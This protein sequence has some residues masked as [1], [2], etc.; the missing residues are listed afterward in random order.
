M[1]KLVENTMPVMVDVLSCCGVPTATANHIYIKSRKKLE[2]IGRDVILSEVEGGNFKN[3]GQDELVSVIERYM[4]C[5]IEGVA[6]RNLRLM[7]K[8]IRGMG[9]KNELTAQS[10]TKYS[11]ALASLTEEEIRHLG[12]LCKSEV[13]SYEKNMK[14]TPPEMNDSERIYQSL[15]RTGLVCFESEVDALLKQSNLIVGADEPDFSGS[16]AIRTRVT[17]VYRITPMMEEIVEYTKFFSD[18]NLAE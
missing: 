2:Q 11:E 3:V 1:R 9:D 17:T 4:R 15:L 16:N 18:E 5:A 6:K 7:A 8:I 14:S 13:V 12:H 10:F